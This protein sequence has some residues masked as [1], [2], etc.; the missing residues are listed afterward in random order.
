MQIRAT[1]PDDRAVVLSVLARYPAGTSELLQKAR[2]S[3]YVLNKKEAYRTASAGLR[4][5]GIDV[6]SW[7]APPAGLFVV[8]ERTVYIRS[9]SEMTIGHELGHAV[10][11]ALGEGAYLSG[12]DPEIRRAFSLARR[13]VTPYAASGLDEYFAEAA[14]SFCELNDAQS[15]WPKAT[16][17]RL[18]QCDPALYAIM[19]RLFTRIATFA[20]QLAG[21]TQAPNPAPATVSEPAGDVMKPRRRSRRKAA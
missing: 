17:A 4:R 9:V 2:C 21:E 8:E 6:D 3:V 10:D 12:V 14:R 19:E 13:Y 7:P 18:L 5:L 20:G 11:L 16:R 1:D 15:P